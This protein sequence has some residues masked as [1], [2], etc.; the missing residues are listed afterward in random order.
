MAL[1]FFGN[2]DIKFLLA[3]YLETLDL[4]G[5]VVVDIPAGRGVTARLLRQRGAQ[6]EAYDLFPEFFDVPELRCRPADLERPLPIADAHADYV[7]CQEGIEHLANP[8]LPLCEFNRILKSGGRLILTTPSISHLRARL[9]HFLLESEIYNR[10]PA[11]EADSVWFANNGQVYFGHLF[12]IGIQKLRTLASLAGFRLVHLHPVKVSPT[13]LLLAPIGYPLLILASLYAYL[14]GIRRLTPDAKAEMK[15][16][17][18]EIVKLN[19]HPTVL[20]GKHLFL[21][22]EKQTD[23]EQLPYRSYKR[24]QEIC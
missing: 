10:L 14:R 17:L 21:E 20:L 23:L 7:V 4:Q 15:P 16:R 11:N 6:V 22:F 18:R 2:G 19:L 3:Q 13:S 8:Y 9:S 1:K 24:R 5:Q 12:L